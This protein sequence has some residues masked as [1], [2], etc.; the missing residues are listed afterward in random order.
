MTSND[1]S[2]LWSIFL[3]LTNRK[4]THCK[5]SESYV[6]KQK[7]IVVHQFCSYASE[8]IPLSYSLK[9]NGFGVRRPFV[10]NVCPPWNWRSHHSCC[11]QDSTFIQPST[12]QADRLRP[13]SL[14]DK[15][16]DPWSGMQIWVL[17]R[18]KPFLENEFFLVCTLF[19][20]DLLIVS[21]EKY[22][23]SEKCK[24]TQQGILLVC[25]AYCLATHFAT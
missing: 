4:K 8:Y 5:S 14:M 3:G 22:I 15:E 17:P 11:L 19:T 7:L 1:Y 12:K 25:M 18:S 9:T 2:S 6:Q 13:D 24:I 16:P 21:H 20:E 10:F 23:P